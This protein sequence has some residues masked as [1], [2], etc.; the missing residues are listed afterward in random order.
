MTQVETGAVLGRDQSLVARV[1]R[2]ERR[3]S[4]LGLRDLCRAF[5]LP[6]AT[7]LDG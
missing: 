6:Y 4:A 3:L 7:V 5:S 2:G 1:E